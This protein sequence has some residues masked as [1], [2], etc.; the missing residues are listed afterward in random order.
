MSYSHDLQCL[1]DRAVSWTGVNQQVRADHMPGDYASEKMFFWLP[2]L[3]VLCSL[4][5]LMAAASDLMPASFLPI[6]GI[7]TLIAVA[8]RKN[9]L[10]GKTEDQDTQEQA[11][12]RSE[13]SRLCYRF[14]LWANILG[15][16]ALYFFLFQYNQ[17]LTPVLNA[18]V[19]T[20]L[21]NLTC[22]IALPVSVA[23]W[24]SRLK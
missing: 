8:I 22:L 20:I 3:P 11:R 18:A 14:L 17:T 13:A 1:L 9:S 21:L 15:Q 10:L 4:F 6:A 24:I 23:S 5:V 7:Q 19:C 16:P 12:I 2:L